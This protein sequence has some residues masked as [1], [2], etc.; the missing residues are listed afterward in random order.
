MCGESVGVVRLARARGAGCALTLETPGERGS[1]GCVGAQLP[2]GVLMS[3]GR[4]VDVEPRESS[5]AYGPQADL[6]LALPPNAQMLLSPAHVNQRIEL[7]ALGP[8]RVLCWMA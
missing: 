5:A 1:C 2:N 7:E 8:E 3:T 6:V 4:V